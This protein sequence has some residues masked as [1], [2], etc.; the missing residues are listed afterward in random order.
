MKKFV[1]LPIKG[2]RPTLV[3]AGSSFENYTVGSELFVFLWFCHLS[4]LL[5]EPF[6]FT[7]LFVL[8]FASTQQVRKKL[9]LVAHG[10][11]R[12]RG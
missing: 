5:L 12:R 11:S 4:C 9:R 2:G 8:S 10:Y 7:S 1:R 6:R 3:K